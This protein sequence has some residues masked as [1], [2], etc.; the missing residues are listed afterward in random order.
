MLERNPIDFQN[1]ITIQPGQRG[2]E[3][4][5]TGLSY[6]KAD[7]IKF[8]YKLEP[9][10]PDWIDAG[11]R[12]IAYF[13]YLPP[14][15]YTFHV[16]AANSDGMWNLAGARINVIVR[17]PFWRRWWFWLVCSIVVISGAAFVIRSRLVQLKKKQL[18]REGFSRKLIESQEAERKRLAGEL[19]DSLA[20]TLLIVK[21]GPSLTHSRQTIPRANI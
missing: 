5:Y 4:G 12:R 2:L 11:T 15:S 14:G 7:Q 3:I 18:E 10:D 13:P 20:Q 8:K 16:I 1:G 17:A 21:I 19:H 6:I 9:L